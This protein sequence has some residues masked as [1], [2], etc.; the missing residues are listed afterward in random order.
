MFTLIAKNPVH[1]AAFTGEDHAQFLRG[2]HAAP[3]DDAP[4]LI[5]AD[6][7]DELG[8]SQHAHVIRHIVQN[9]AKVL[10]HQYTV[11]GLSTSSTPWPWSRPYN[12]TYYTPHRVRR[13]HQAQGTTGWVWR[14]SGYRPGLFSLPQIRRIFGDD[15]YRE[16]LTRQ[17]LHGTAVPESIAHDLELGYRIFGDRPNG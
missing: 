10:P 11:A 13:P 4:K 17:G 6:R 3:H 2:V 12:L 8:H 16:L 1:L 14:L 15:K 5:Y 7:L 9:K